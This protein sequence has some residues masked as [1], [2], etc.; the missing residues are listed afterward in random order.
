MEVSVS[1][2]P[3]DNSETLLSQPDIWHASI[4]MA[5]DEYSTRSISS[6]SVGE[7][8]RPLEVSNEC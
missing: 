8:E 1:E 7:G 6:H 2:S 4:P 5:G 3:S